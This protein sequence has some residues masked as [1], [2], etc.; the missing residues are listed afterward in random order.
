M[1]YLTNEI[2]AL[3]I[4]R[5]LFEILPNHPVNLGK[6][7]IM[8]SIISKEC[9]RRQ[10]EF[11]KSLDSEEVVY[12]EYFQSLLSYVA[13]FMP[14][15]NLFFSDNSP[16]IISDIVGDLVRATKMGRAFLPE[17]IGDGNKRLQKHLS[18]VSVWRGGRCYNY[19]A[20]ALYHLLEAGIRP[21]D[22]LWLQAPSEKPDNPLGHQIVV[23][24]LESDDGYK[25]LSQSNAVIL[26]F[27][28]GKIIPAHEYF[29]SDSLFHGFDASVI[30]CCRIKEGEKNPFQQPYSIEPENIKKFKQST[31][32]AIVE[33]IN[34]RRKNGEA[35]PEFNLTE[36]ILRESEQSCADVSDLEFKNRTS[37]IERNLSKLGFFEDSAR[38]IQNKFRETHLKPRTSTVLS[39]SDLSVFTKLSNK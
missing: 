28:S 16:Q 17:I 1:S 9:A 22:S 32:E 2:N 21:I 38:K 19:A 3:L 30:Q 24:G 4:L 5:K 13:Q 39:P 11:N 18:E 20:L 15:N 33:I 26:D 23:I 37:E 8:A 14:L 25:N 31:S 10:K 34:Q 29:K 12:F 6:A 27:W 35:I 36:E 7:Y